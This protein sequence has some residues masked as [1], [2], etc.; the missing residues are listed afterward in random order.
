MV[1][2]LAA[3]NPAS[4]TAA[5]PVVYNGETNASMVQQVGRYWRRRAYPYAYG[6]GYPAYGYNYGY[7][8]YG[9]CRPYA[10][11][12]GPY[13][14]YGAPHGYYGRPGISFSFGY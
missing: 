6:G 7:R 3:P 10:Y 1:V 11:Y 5:T 8:P 12:G 9:Y 14:Y 13:G 2:V 4:A